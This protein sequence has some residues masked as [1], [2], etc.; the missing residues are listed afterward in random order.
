MPGLLRAVAR[1]AGQAVADG[2]PLGCA[3]DPLT[4]RTRWGSG[5]TLAPLLA[6]PDQQ[7]VGPGH[8][9]RP[10]RSALTRQSRAAAA[11]S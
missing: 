10:T 4:R 1:T 2:G 8:A 11:S 6:D 5:G 9:V 7:P 3:P